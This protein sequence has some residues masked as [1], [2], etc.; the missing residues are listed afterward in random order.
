MDARHF[1]N[2][3]QN[4]ETAAAAVA[5]EGVGRVGDQLK[6]LEDELRDDERAIDEAGFTDVGDAAVD[7]DARIEDLAAARR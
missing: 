3:L 7:D 4:V 1:L 5:P 6:L 2:F